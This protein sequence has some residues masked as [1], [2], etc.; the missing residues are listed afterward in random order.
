MKKD[1]LNTAYSQRV[2]SAIQ[3]ANDLDALQQ[4]RTQYLGSKSDLMAALKTL[5]EISDKKERARIGNTLNILKDTIEDALLLRKETLEVEREN[6]SPVDLSHTYKIATTMDYGHMHPTS[7]VLGETYKIFSQ[8]G[9]AIVDSDEIESDWYNFEALNMPHEHPA[10]D[11]QDTFYIAESD[12]KLLPRTHTSGMQ[13]RYMEQH[14]PPYKIIV[15]GRVF[16]NED[17]DPTHIWSFYQVEGLVVGEGVTMSDLKGTL[18]HVVRGLLG[19]EADIRFRPSYFPYTEPS[20]E[21]DCLYQGK[22]L[23]LGGAGMVHPQ[24]LRNGG[25]DPDKYSGYAFG[26]G[27]ERIANI[28]FG[29]TDLRELWRPRFRFLEQF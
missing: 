3:Q 6:Y 7:T 25:V 26:W 1:I 8:L 9:F 28:K 11:M 23:E 12:M 15:P 21:L 13:V 19:E 18:L 2:V 17:E 29:L 10:R 22:W 20:V 24:V 16:R 14:T 5:K 4:L 27:A